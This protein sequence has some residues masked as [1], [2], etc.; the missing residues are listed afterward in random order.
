MLK[1]IDNFEGYVLPD[2]TVSAA[3]AFAYNYLVFNGE[4]LKYS[5]VSSTPEARYALSTTS[6]DGTLIAKKLTG[7]W[8][9][10]SPIHL[11]IRLLNFPLEAAFPTSIGHMGLARHNGTSVQGVLLK[12]GF[13]SSALMNVSWVEEGLVMSES[14]TLSPA[15]SGNSDYVE[16]RMVPGVDGILGSM[17][18]WVNNRAIFTRDIVPADLSDN[19]VAWIVLGNLTNKVVGTPSTYVQ[20]SVA[21]AATNGKGVVTDFYIV[22]S[23]SGLNV[24]RL[25]RI[26]V[27]SRV[28]AG[29]IGP[30]EWDTYSGSTEPS[31]AA[32]LSVIPPDPA[33][34]ISASEE[35]KTEM[36]AGLAFPALG[37]E[38]VVGMM[39]RILA[40]KDDPLG[41][42]VK[43]LVT[44]G[45]AEAEGEAVALGSTPTY[46][47]TVF[48]TNP[49]TESRWTAAEINNSRFGFVS[50]T[51][52]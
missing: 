34:F 22:D 44:S 8:V 43:A 36:Y 14:V 46:V 21:G 7:V 12:I 41:P 26:R 28:P 25:G 27:T 42:D 18:V 29:D 38:E 20:D 13:P 51:S 10:E 1:W 39:T 11:G 40:N 4:S 47:N 16:V 32:I 49:A 6:A 24:E 52:A 3:S 9:A 35:T 50:E 17:S 5:L 33:K 15:L 19:E 2:A 23:Q 31:H 45:S 48:E 37:G 30:N